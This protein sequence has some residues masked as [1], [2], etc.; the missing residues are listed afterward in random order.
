MGMYEKMLTIGRN[1][2]DNLLFEGFHGVGK[3]QIIENWGI[4][5][6]FYVESLL[7]SH[8]E[9]GDIVG[10]PYIENKTTYG[11]KPSF[12]KRM[13]EAHEKGQHCVLFLDEL[14]RANRDV[15]DAALQ[16]CLKGEISDHKLPVKD[17]KKTFIVA[18]IN[19]SEFYQVNELDPALLDRFTLIQFQP[20]FEDWIKW[21]TKHKVHKVVIDF[22]KSKPKYLHNFKEVYNQEKS[23]A[24]TP[25]S[26]VQLSEILYELEKDDCVLELLFTFSYGRIGNIATEF[27]NYYK[28]YSNV[29]SKELLYK[30]YNEK[31][32][33][34]TNKKKMEALLDKYKVQTPQL[35]D[36]CRNMV[37]DIGDNTLIKPI[38]LYFNIIPLEITTAFLKELKV[39][40]KDEYFKLIDLDKELFQKIA[41]IMIMEKLK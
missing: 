2:N 31:H 38:L 32:T 20:I 21:A 6:G 5:N 15:L 27:F 30:T 41:K 26:W 13:D 39:N 17:G 36:V 12:L 25:R 23:N 24:A 4:E 34:E 11:A 40:N 22:L 3:S 29:F 9:I 33:I 8:Y 16:L 37:K 7:L 14:N 35:M 10:S 1:A 19:P 18:A 28:N